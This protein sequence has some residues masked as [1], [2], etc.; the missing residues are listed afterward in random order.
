[1]VLTPVSTIF[2]LYIVAVF[3]ITELFTTTISPYYLRFFIIKY[4]LR[5]T[6]MKLRSVGVM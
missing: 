5:F 6:I 4:G 3:N 2:Q 1:M